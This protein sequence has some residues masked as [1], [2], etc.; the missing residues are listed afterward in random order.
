M[1]S[2]ENIQKSLGLTVW[3]MTWCKTPKRVCYG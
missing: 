1:D 3:T 2:A